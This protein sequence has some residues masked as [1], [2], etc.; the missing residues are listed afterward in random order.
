MTMRHIALL[1]ALA[2]APA[3]G[4][5]GDGSGDESTNP[6]PEPT[7]TA[8]PQPEP[9]AAQ[10]TPTPT[11]APSLADV[12]LVPV[13]SGLDSPLY[14]TS[15]PGEPERLFI[16]EQRG[17]IRIVEFGSVREEP[18]LDLGDVVR[19]GG[20]LGLLGLAFDP[21]YAESGLLYVNYTNHDLVS[22][23][24]EFSVDVEDP[25]RAIRDS[26]RVLLEVPQDTINHHA[27]MLEF[28]PGGGLYVALGDSAQGADPKGYAQDPGEFRGKILRLD[29]DT[30][31][32][33]IPGNP[34]FENPH[35]WHLGLRN[36]WRFSFDRATGDMYIG[37]VG[38]VET[39]EISVVPA[40]VSGANFGWNVTEGAQCFLAPWSEEPRPMCDSAGFVSPAWVHGRDL[41]CSVTGGYVYRGP[42]VAPLVGRY[43][44]SDYCSRRIFSFVWEDGEATDLV[45]M[46]EMLGSRDL[47]QGPSSF[48]EDLAGNLYVVDLGGA[49]YRFDMR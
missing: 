15:A 8:E 43:V 27:G 41:G 29:P 17:T 35:V 18:F 37:D 16:V 38:E 25:S 2:C 45:D 3:C 44:F 1:L 42:S 39:E 46:S 4:G 26:E 23:T 22:I 6:Q 14:L 32:E 47:L 49:V 9:T 36:P 24:S 40:G 33:P 34:G 31:P 11:A 10:P 5:G 7:A 13:V 30:F 21:D 48:G 12:R 28:G 20:E 19:S